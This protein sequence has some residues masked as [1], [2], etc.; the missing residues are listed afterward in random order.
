MSL[1]LITFM[2]RYSP[3]LSRLTAF[4]VCDFEAVTLTFY[5]MFLNIHRGV[6]KCYFSICLF[7]VKENKGDQWNP[8]SLRP[9]IHVERKW[10]WKRSGS[11]SGT[12]FYGCVRGNVSEIMVFKEAET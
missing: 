3:L 2:Y 5:H 12:D 11:W 8:L 4:V 9:P 7:H 10:P 1:L 6:L